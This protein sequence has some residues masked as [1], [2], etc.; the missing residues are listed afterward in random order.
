MPFPYRPYIRGMVV[1]AI[2]KLPASIV[3]TVFYFH[4]VI[5]SGTLQN[6]SRELAEIEE[7]LEEVKL[8][9]KALVQ[10][11]KELLAA[12]YVYQTNPSELEAELNKPKESDTPDLK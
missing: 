4:A 1:Y 10:R 9:R 2:Y 11:K 5:M 8:D 7:E 3:Y 6:L 12:L